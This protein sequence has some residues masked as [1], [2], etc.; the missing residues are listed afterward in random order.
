M[1]GGSSKEKKRRGKNNV[2]IF[3]QYIDDVFHKRVLK[4]TG[5]YFFSG[6]LDRTDLN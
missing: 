3:T 1:D 5:L 4:E 6:F 2:L